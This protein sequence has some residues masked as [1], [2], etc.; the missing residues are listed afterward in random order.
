ME[1][2]AGCTLRELERGADLG[3]ASKVLSEM[4]R[5]GYRVRKVRASVPCVA[6]TRSR[7]G[8]LRLFLEARP[9]EVQ[10]DL[11]PFE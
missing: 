3:S 6:G 8:A 5:R 2:H 7:R 10:R 9:A 4:L 1:A 11:F